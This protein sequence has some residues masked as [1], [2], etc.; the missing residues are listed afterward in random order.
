M[1]TIGVK[2][3]SEMIHKTPSTIRTYTS[4][5]P[6]LLPPRLDVPGKILLWEYS[7][8]VE[9]MHGKHQGARRRI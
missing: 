3:L 4:R 8:V 7:V 6:E 1:K 9:W 2:E 5:N